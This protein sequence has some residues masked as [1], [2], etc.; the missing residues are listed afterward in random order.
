MK[1]LTKAEEQVMQALWKIGQGFI[2]DLLQAMPDPK[3]HKNT[4][5]TVLKIL[6]DK[7]YVHVRT[8]GRLHQYYPLISKASYTKYK[9]NQHQLKY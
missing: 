9:K 2:K 7:Q 5:A 8:Y 4:L 3:P 6:I 1:S